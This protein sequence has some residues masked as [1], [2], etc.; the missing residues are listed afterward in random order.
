MLQVGD[1][2]QHLGMCYKITKIDGDA[3]H[4]QILRKSS[5]PRCRKA[6]ATVSLK[7]LTPWKAAA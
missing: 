6:F 4:I 1:K 7:S 3:A 5:G 2:V